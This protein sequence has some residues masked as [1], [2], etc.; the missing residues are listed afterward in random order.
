MNGKK[1]KDPVG[2]TNHE[3]RLFIPQKNDV[4]VAHFLNS[5]NQALVELS[6]SR[7]VP[8]D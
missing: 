4:V 7:T 3:P 2:A 1:V 5:R 8:S 6:R